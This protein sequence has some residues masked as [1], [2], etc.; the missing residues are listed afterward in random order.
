MLAPEKELVEN[1]HGVRSTFLSIGK[2]LREKLESES[3]IG[4][5]GPE[6]PPSVYFIGKLLWSK[7]IGS[8][9]DLIKYA[10]ETADLVIDL[11]MYGGGPDAEEAEAKSRKLGLDMKFRGPIDHASLAHSH[12]VSDE[13]D[14]YQPHF[15]HSAYWIPS[16]AKSPPPHPTPTPDIYQSFHV[17]SFMHY[18]SRSVGNGKIRY[19][20]FAPFERLLCAISQLSAIYIERGVRS[21]VIL[22]LDPLT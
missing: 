22:C 12:K 19:S 7:G 17:G 18:C 14:I 8:L 10:E 20:A 9:M 6:A 13:E 3:D 11:D 15:F 16:H 5:F 4:V 2:E 21:H 1:V